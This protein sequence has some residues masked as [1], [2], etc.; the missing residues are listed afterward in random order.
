MGSVSEMFLSDATVSK[1]EKG[2]HSASRPRTGVVRTII[3]SVG[4]RTPGVLLS[5]GLGP[6]SAI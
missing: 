3:S 6:N 2:H 4:E 1:G 5:E